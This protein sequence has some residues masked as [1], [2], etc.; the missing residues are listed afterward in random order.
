MKNNIDITFWAIFKNSKK[1]TGVFRAPFVKQ[2]FDYCAKAWML[3]H[4]ILEGIYRIRKLV[5]LRIETINRIQ[6]SEELNILRVL[7][8]SLVIKS[9]W[10]YNDLNDT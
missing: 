10:A 2:K 8:N 5:N 3:N 4:S 9:M 6:F 1:C 7:S